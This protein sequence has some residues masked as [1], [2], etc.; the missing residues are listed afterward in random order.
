M[1]VSIIVPAHNEESNLPSLLDSLLSLIKSG[2]WGGEIVVVDD[3]SSDGTAALADSYSKRHRNIKV[4][5]RRDGK[6][7]MG[8][9]LREGTAAASGDY[10]IWTMADK[11]DNILTFPKIIEKLGSGFDVVFGSRHVRGGS[12]GDLSLHKAFF[13]WLYSNAARVAFGLNA[14]DITNA[15]RG[16]RKSAFTSLQLD[17]GD[18]A[19]SPEF[20]IK[21]HLAGFRLGE[22]PT[23]YSDRKRG[24]T[25]F[26]ILKM[27]FR[28][29]SLFKYLLVKPKKRV[30]PN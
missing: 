4:I 13:S 19:I 7:G 22:V 9:S 2:K 11:S 15:F 16:F 28:Y 12:Y 27:G 26:S 25:T 6:R 21:A 5:H 3:H 30:K 23:T 24:R 1:K 29:G 18:F 10:V 20:A 8:Y 17:S 14:H